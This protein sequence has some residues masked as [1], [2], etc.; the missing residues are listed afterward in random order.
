MPRDEVRLVSRQPRLSFPH[1]ISHSITR[2][3]PAYY[4]CPTAF[5]ES[6]PPKKEVKKE[7]VIRHAPDA[8]WTAFHR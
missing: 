7:I 4:N 1:E 2:L 8:K 3:V 5:A 6:E